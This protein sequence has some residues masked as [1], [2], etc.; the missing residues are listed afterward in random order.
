MLVERPAGRSDRDVGTA[1]PGCTVH[2][3]LGARYHPRERDDEGPPGSLRARA[4]LHGGSGMTLRDGFV[5]SNAVRRWVA[6][7]RRVGVQPAVHDVMVTSCDGDGTVVARW[8]LR[9]ATLAPARWLADRELVFTCE[10]I[11]VLATDAVT[12]APAPVFER[13]RAARAGARHPGG[14]PGT[15]HGAVTAAG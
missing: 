4:D 10:W 9:R 1:E 6:E 11:D 15:G 2:V 8:C 5:I 13:R 7:S 3:E 12:T 14:M